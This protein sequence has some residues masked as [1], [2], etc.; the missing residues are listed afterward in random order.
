MP[1]LLEALPLRMSN[2]ASGH[3]GTET[4]A[5]TASLQ[6]NGLP[7]MCL[8]LLHILNQ[9]TQCLDSLRIIVRGRLLPSLSLQ[10]HFPLSRLR[11]GA[12]AQTEQLIRDY[13]LWFA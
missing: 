13:A 2:H 11:T 7:I 8:L 9:A 10:Y 6:R 1:R 12:S 3:Q 4:W 5:I